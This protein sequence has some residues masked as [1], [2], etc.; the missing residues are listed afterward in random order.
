MNPFR[1]WRAYRWRKRVEWFAE[2]AFRARAWR[3]NPFNTKTHPPEL[4]RKE[5]EF[6]LFIPAAAPVVGER[7]GAV[8]CGLAGEPPA[9]IR[10]A[11][12]R[13][14]TPVWTVEEGREVTE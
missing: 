11:W 10:E 5:L 3:D 6:T 9:E 13:W 1:L 8:D 12:A 7:F 4:V 2:A 14:T